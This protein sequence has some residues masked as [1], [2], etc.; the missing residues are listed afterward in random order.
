VEDRVKA[1]YAPWTYKRLVALKNTSDPTNFF[2]LNQNIRPIPFLKPAALWGTKER[3][4][5]LFGE[6]ITP[7]QMRKRNI[8]KEAFSPVSRQA[9][10]RLKRDTAPKTAGH[11]I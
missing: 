10:S 5:E 11:F 1:A 2:R 4:H 8:P 6:G 3:V 7:L 9:K